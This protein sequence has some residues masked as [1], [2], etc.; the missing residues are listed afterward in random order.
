MLLRVALSCCSPSLCTCTFLL[1]KCPAWAVG[2]CTCDR[3]ILLS[4]RLTLAFYVLIPAI[5]FVFLHTTE[6]I[7]DFQIRPSAVKG[8]IKQ[9]Y[10][11][12]CAVFSCHR[13]SSVRCRSAWPSWSSSTNSTVAW[14]GRTALTPPADSRIWC[15][16][17]T[18][19]G[20]T[21]RRG[22][23]PSYVD[24]RWHWLIGPCDLLRGS[25]ET[26]LLKMKKNKESHLFVCLTLFL[27]TS[28][29]R[30]RSSRRH[31]TASWCGWQRW[32]S[33]WPT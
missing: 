16:M 11:R 8:L 18:D 7:I 30:G 28:S 12:I 14:R 27:S 13:P 4:P 19:G 10:N 6:Q 26:T 20:I 21:C 32:T 1:A 29:A 17:G 24:L 23:P 15:M 25:S 9:S 5:P 31:E 22:W 2:I 3:L 33:S